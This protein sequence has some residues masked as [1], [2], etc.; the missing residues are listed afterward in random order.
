MSDRLKALADAGVSIWLDDLSRERIESGN[1]AELVE[2]RFVV[3]V[4]T[5]PTI[6]ASAIANGER[7]DEQVAQLVEKGEPVD[8]VVFELTTEDVRNACDIM[9]PVHEATPADGR[10]S[11][12]VEPDLANDTEGTIASARALWSAVDRPNAFVKI[13]ATKEGLPAITAGIAEGISVNVTLIFSIE[14]YRE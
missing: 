1:L 11:I 10:V 12:E 3:G 7:Y 13:P 8:R 2:R 5:N 14:R 6:F 9:R 4:T